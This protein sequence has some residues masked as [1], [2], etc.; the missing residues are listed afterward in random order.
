MKMNLFKLKQ[1]RVPFYALLFLSVLLFACKK[2]NNNNTAQTYSTSGNANGN[3]ETP[4]NNSSG[5]GTL[6]GTYNSATNVWQYNISWSSLSS[7]ASAVQ[8]RG[9]ASVGVSGALMFTLTITAPGINGSASGNVVL[10]DQQE[11]DLLA[12]KCYYTILSSTYLSGE[13]RG[14]ITATAN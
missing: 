5:S 14:Q 8:M 3:Q 9:P 10:T 13:I 4:A 1:I 7:A 12:N 6:T 2:E 11:A